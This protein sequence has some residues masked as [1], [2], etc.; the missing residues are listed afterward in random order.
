MNRTKQELLSPPIGVSAVL[1]LILL[2]GI[3]RFGFSL[4]WLVINALGIACL[5]LGTKIS[6]MNFKKVTKASLLLGV[7]VVFLTIFASFRGIS[8]IPWAIV[9]ATLW[10]LV[11][12]LSAISSKIFNYNGFPIHSILI[13][14]IGALFIV[15][16]FSRYGSW[17]AIRALPLTPPEGAFGMF[18]LFISFPSIF[19]YLLSSGNR[20]LSSLFIALSLGLMLLHGFRAD[21]ALILLSSFIIVYK[22]GSRSSYILLAI[23]L[24]LFL[25]VD[26]IRADI[27]VPLMDRIAYRL[28]T[29]Y[30]Y[31]MELLNWSLSLSL[32]RDPLWLFSVPLHPSQTIGRGIFGKEYGITP[33]IFVEFSLLYGILGIVLLSSLIGILSGYSYRLFKENRDHSSYPIIWSILITRAEIGLSQLDFALIAGSVVFAIL[34]NLINGK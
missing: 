25:F 16:S 9:I 14:V 26:L 6:H 22:R 20:T 18:L 10:T 5:Y 8:G 21:A 3:P 23:F 24:V 28:G 15:H 19:E 13:Y 2:S 1:F 33:T 11:L 27:N 4:L 30:Y 32:A 7:L 29:T 31:S 12:G 34:A 17:H